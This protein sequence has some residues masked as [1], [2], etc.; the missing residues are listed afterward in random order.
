MNIATA[1]KVVTVSFDTGVTLMGT[2]ASEQDAEDAA[3]GLN[4]G[5]IP[6]TMSADG[7][8]R[9]RNFVQLVCAAEHMR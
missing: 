5:S 4:M 9:Y 2:F 6:T 8:R 3:Y 1:G 7:A